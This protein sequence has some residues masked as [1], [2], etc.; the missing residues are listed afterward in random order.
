MILYT[1]ETFIESLKWLERKYNFVFSNKSDLM[2]LCDEIEQNTGN[3]LPAY[4]TKDDEKIKWIFTNVPERFHSPGDFLASKKK[5]EKKKKRRIRKDK[6]KRDRNL[7]KIRSK[8][9]YYTLNH[10]F[11]GSEKWRKLR[12]RVLKKYNKVCMCCGS[13]NKIQV[14]HI[15]PRSKYPRLEFVFQNLQVLCEECNFR[16]SNRTNKDYRPLVEQNRLISYIER[17]KIEV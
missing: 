3:S 2:L 8:K 6:Y 12:N 15:Y 14:D 9:A 1:N 16:K 4:I 17:N 7:K 11:Y 10:P 13:K 5:F